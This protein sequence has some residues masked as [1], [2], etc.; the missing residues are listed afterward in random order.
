MSDVKRINPRRPFEITTEGLKRVT[1][2]QAGEAGMLHLAVSHGAAAPKPQRLSAAPK[3][4]ILVAA[5]SDR[6]AL[7][8]HGHQAIAAAALLADAETAVLVQVLGDLAE[9]LSPYGADRV[10]VL[11]APAD[12]AFV[13]ELELAVLHDLVARYGPRHILLPDNDVGDGDLGRRLAASLEAEVATHVVELSAKGVAAYWQGGALMARRD[14]P[15]ILLL[16]PETTDLALPFLG[17]G[18]RLD[19]VAPAVSHGS[20][21]DLGVASIDAAHVALEEADFIVSAGNG[22]GDLK[23]FEAVAKAFGAAVGASRVAVDDGKFPREKQ[24][25]ATGK[26]V[27]ASVYMAIGISGAVQHLQGIRACRHVIA[28]NTDAGA[29]IA[30]RADLTVV[31]DAEDI[32][33]ALLA[34]AATRNWPGADGAAAE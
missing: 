17:E 24:I 15:R 1:L 28:I 9:D 8:A 30:K 12:G 25:G 21:R 22:V 34:A 6:G 13:P 10:A 23:S 2:G 19:H 29:P 18:Q 5:H 32:M 4:Y 26:T 33:R 11:P 20:Y 3:G 14:L 31:A 16:A 7:D 27:N